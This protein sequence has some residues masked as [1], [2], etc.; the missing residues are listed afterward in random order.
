MTTHLDNSSAVDLYGLPL[1]AGDTPA[2]VRWSGRA[3]DAVVAYRQHRER[4]DLY[5]SALEVLLDGE[6][7]VIEMTPVWPATKLDRGVVC[8]GPVGLRWLGH[9]RFFRYEVRCWR[10]GAIPECC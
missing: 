6:R 4:Q 9:S 3:F 2:I 8:E 5:H 1:G 7:F 10:D